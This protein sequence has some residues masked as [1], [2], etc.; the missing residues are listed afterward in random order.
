MSSAAKRTTI[1]AAG[2]APFGA[3][4]QLKRG[5][6]I[7]GALSAIIVFSPVLIAIALAIRLTSP[8]PVFFVQ[9][10]LGLHGQ[11]Y[12][13]LKFRSM[14]DNAERMGTGL[15]S[16]EGDPR[17]TRV[18]HILR[19]FSLDELAQI[20][21]VLGGSMSLVG[22]RPPVTYELGPWEDYT[23]HMRRRFDVKPGITGLAQISGRNE[24]DWD[25]KVAIDNQYVDLYEKVGIWIDLKILIR[26]VG[27]VLTG[28]DT[29]ETPPEGEEGP[30]ARRARRA[31]EERET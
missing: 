4:K 11:E 15:F 23:P 25:T 3:F 9:G 16:Y 12:Q 27:V 14:V 7:L 1:T 2:A 10:R 30:I 17:I 13:M 22:P 26:T 31:T 5:L 21:N 8:G 19:K 28:R 20:F 29:I 18:G 24:L 6:D